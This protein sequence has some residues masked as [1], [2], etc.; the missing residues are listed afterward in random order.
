MSMM[1]SAHRSG[2]RS[3]ASGSAAM[4]T[5][6]RSVIL[7]AGDATDVPPP[8]RGHGHTAPSAR[9]PASE[10]GGGIAG[11]VPARDG[12]MPVERGSRAPAAVGA[13]TCLTYD[14]RTRR[15][16]S[17]S[18][19]DRRRCARRTA[20]EPAPSA[21]RQR[22]TER[23]G[24]SRRRISCST[25]QRRSWPHVASSGSPPL[26]GTRKLGTP[27]SPSAKS[28]SRLRLELV[29]PAVAVEMRLRVATSRDRRARRRDAVPRRCPCRCPRRRPRAGTSA[30]T[31]S[32]APRRRRTGTARSRA[33]PVGRRDRRRGR[34]ATPSV[35][36]LALR[37]ERDVEALGAAAP[38]GRASPSAAPAAARGRPAA[39]A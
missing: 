8:A 36:G 27:Q 18:R 3:N 11:R 16:A 4:L 2:S 21:R 30:G 7:R 6:C 25:S 33:R 38:A 15:I 37:V 17:A 14:R 19:R 35:L 5:M 29:L 39:A 12:R 28:A 24:S 1:S 34:T 9:A 23:A 22:A 26:A 13:R 32:R 31:R 20:R 10:R